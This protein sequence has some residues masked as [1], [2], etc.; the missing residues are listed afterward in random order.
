MSIVSKHGLS[1]SDLRAAL[2]TGA[3]VQRL[4][5]DF[6]AGVRRSVNATPTF[7]I[8]GVRYVG[9]IGCD[10]LAVALERSATAIECG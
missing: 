7:F 8:D 4:E 6:V 1:I 5:A 2:E 10:A 3:Y 9:P